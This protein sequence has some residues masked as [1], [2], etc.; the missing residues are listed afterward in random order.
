M[1]PHRL[2]ITSKA[3]LAAQ[4]MVQFVGAIATELRRL[5]RA[6]LDSTTLATMGPRE[7]RNA[8]KAALAAHH[9]N[10]SRCC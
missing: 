5:N 2:R 8:V 10:S 3:R 9:H 7:R 1:K 4:A 6:R